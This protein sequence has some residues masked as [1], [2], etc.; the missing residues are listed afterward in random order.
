M[1]RYE[2]ACDAGCDESTDGEPLGESSEQR[3]R[4]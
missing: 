2:D 1:R 4:L 3:E